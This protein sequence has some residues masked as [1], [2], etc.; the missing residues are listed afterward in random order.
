[1]E[2]LL[3]DLKNGRV[4]SLPVT[5][6]KFEGDRGEFYDQEDYNGRNYLCAL[7][8]DGDCSGCAA[9]GTGLFPWTAGRRGRR[10]GSLTLRE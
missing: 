8:T 10:I 9:V 2:P 6:G 3:G 4:F 5:V 1:M 7:Q